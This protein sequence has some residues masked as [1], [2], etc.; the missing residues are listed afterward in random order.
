MP[1]KKT[2]PTLPIMPLRST[3]VYPSAAMSIQIGLEATL[4]M[5]EANPD[6]GLEVVTVVDAGGADDPI[7]PRALKKVGVAAR[8]TDRLYMPG[9]S[10]QATIQG[11]RRVR[12]QGV[13]ERDGY[14]VARIR[15]VR[16]PEPEPTAVEEAI[17]RILSALESLAALVERVPAEVPA[18]LRMNVGKP[19]R[20]ADLV[21]TL[22][23]FTVARKDEVL[24]R[25]DVGKRLDFVLR[26]LEGELAHLRQLEAAGDAA[27]GSGG[28][29]GAAPSA[30]VE[31]PSSPPRPRERAAEL[32][33][34]IGRLQV[35]LG[36][37]DPAEREIVHRLRRIEAADLPPHVAT[38]AR[39]EIERLRTVG[40]DGSEAEEIR[41]Y[42][43]WLLAMPWTRRATGGP[44]E[45]DLERVR[46]VMDDRL[47]GLDEPKERLL[48][49][50]AVARLRG[51]LRGPIPCIV[52]PP[53]VGKTSLLCAVA[54][55]LGRPLARIELSGKGEA[56]LIGARRPHR[57]ARPGRIAG[58]LR[59]VGVCDPMI[60]L[61]ELDL[62]GAGKVEGD[63]VA[64]LEEALRWTA[65]DAFV[66]R[67]LG[68]EL[69]LSH[70]VIMAT[71][72][73]FRRIPSDIRELLVEIRIAGYTPEEKVDIAREKLL[74]RMIREHGL[75]PDDVT[76]PDDALYELIRGYARDSGLE[77]T[78]RTLATL[79][80]T[81]ARAKAGGEDGA[82]AFDEDRVEEILGPARYIATPAESAPEVG[83]VT[84]LAWTAAGGELLFIEALRMAGTGRLIVTGHLGDV[85]RESVSAA[86]SYVR[87]RAPELDIPDS[88]FNDVDVHVH[89]PVGAVP[90]DGPS[91]GIAVTL[92]V[93]S[94]FS[95]LPVRHDVAM[96][97]EVTLRG[98]VLEVGGIK[99]KVLAAY[100]AGIRRVILPAGNERDLREVPDNVRENVTFTLVERMDEV[101]DLALMRGPRT[102]GGADGGQ[103]SRKK[104]AGG[105]TRA[106][107]ERD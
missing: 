16:E 17:T 42:V 18:V 8:I 22:A 45:I 23:N 21:A 43:D 34:Q 6:E 10:V 67:Y 102:E 61:E 50:L 38:R 99:E 52:G 32:R 88:D 1:P 74:P 15:E 56:D 4:A 76:F 101:L 24:Q 86:Y 85:M 35:E 93:A 84:G 90:K 83:V 54:D 25:L 91:A 98:K 48:D 63:P 73:D 7:D 82:W 19:G 89:F 81:R 71:A 72:Q 60:L 55:G 70:A 33:R 58:A 44:S 64:A 20:F 107:R 11:G 36:R 3:V 49:D 28:S 62:L 68:V 2:A 96:T 87:S 46:A 104:D 41:A 26:E 29:G 9:G 14:W 59:D 53:D 92:A 57:D 97:G 39:T 77:R 31:S 105:E 79:L 66:D 40:A 75:E 78:R 95:G 30:E 47:L 103:R 27:G 13:E 12:V 5:L 80:R 100:R 106:A 69:D 37:V 51:D 65:R 94:T